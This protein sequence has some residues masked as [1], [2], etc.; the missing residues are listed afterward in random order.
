MLGESPNPFDLYKTG[1]V[2]DVVI[3]K[4][5]PDEHRIALSVKDINA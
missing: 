1:D 2:I 4:F 5:T 3:K